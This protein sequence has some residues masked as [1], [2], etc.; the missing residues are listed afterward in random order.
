MYDYLIIGAG[1]AGSV[2]AERLATQ[3]NSR[4]HIIE[5]R[6]HIG[7]NCY[8]AVDSS[9]VIVHRYGPH[10]FHTDNTQAFEYLQSFG[11]WQEYMHEVI[12]HVDGVNIAIPFSFTTLYQVFDTQ[13]ADALKAKLIEQY[14]ED[15]KVSVMELRQAEDSDLKALGD[16]VF[17]KI[18][19]NYTAKQWGIGAD[20]IDPAVL[21]RVPVLTSYD[22]RY[23][24]DKHQAIPVEGY[25]K[26]FE[27]ML[28]HPNI[29]ISLGEEALDRIAI[30]GDRV[31]LDGE[32]F[33]G[34]VVFTG[35]V[36]E[37]FGYSLGK[38][39][40]RSLRL[41][42]EVLDREYYQEG[43]VVNYPNEHDYT[44]ITEFK[45]IHPTKSSQTTILK[46]YPQAYKRGQNIPY[47][48]IPTDESRVIYQ[49]YKEL[50]SRVDNL[51][52]LGRLA[53]YRYYDMDDIVARAL[54]IYEE[55]SCV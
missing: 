28:N 53:E 8:D 17:E 19:V 25:T 13:K 47:Y 34:K 39:P 42:F 43:A 46:E 40:Y 21:A 16:F 5:R 37:L 51:L 20:E 11:E 41:E 31:Y 6:D 35:M 55:L 30:K 22:T 54:Q 10:L 15:Q 24:Q 3:K 12:A 29:S 52:L 27:A 33:A 26:L 18:F 50:A 4:V 38:L 45:Y 2:L 23:F 14:G 48:P 49:H 1:Y 9:G 7:G 32:P 44:R 36:D